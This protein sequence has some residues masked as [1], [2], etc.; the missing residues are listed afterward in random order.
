MINEVLAASDGTI[1]EV[2][3]IELYNPTD[4]PIDL[5]DHYLT[6]SGTEFT[7]KY[8]IPD[9]TILGS[10]EYLVFDE[11]QF[12]AGRSG[13]RLRL[14]QRFGRDAFAAQGAIP[15]RGY[16]FIADSVEF[17][18]SKTSVSLG[19]LPNGEGP[20]CSPTR[21]SRSARRT[22]SIT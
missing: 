12:G 17:D 8:R 18:G 2:D 14:E 9:G 1:G 22:N 20:I 5:T 4:E 19:R 21:S 16:V 10:G 6:D 13:Q 15:P 3:K 7:L 11:T